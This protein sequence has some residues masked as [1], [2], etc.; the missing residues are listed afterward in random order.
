MKTPRKTPAASRAASR[1][2]DTAKSD[3]TPLPSAA[4][5]AREERRRSRGLLIGG[6]IVL[7][8]LAGGVGAYLG[9]NASRMTNGLKQAAYYEDKGAYDEAL[10]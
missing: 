4:P 8:L 10:R 7:L 3:R 6:I 5:P 9:I 1:A 2:P